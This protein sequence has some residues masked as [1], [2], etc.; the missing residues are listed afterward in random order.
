MPSKAKYPAPDLETVLQQQ[1]GII[2]KVA[3]M[4]THDEADF[5]DLVQDISVQVWLSLKKYKKSYALSTWVYRIALNV[6][7]DR[8]RREERRNKNKEAFRAEPL[9]QQT[10]ASSERSEQLHQWVQALPPLDRAL[11]ML[12]LEDYAHEEIAKMIG[13]SKSNV[14][15]K[16]SRLKNR[17]KKELGN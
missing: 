11:M 2:F 7:I 3:R 6:S 17:L 5:E 12:Y 15:T 13:I 16:I 10:N 8:L 1:R 4:Y 14:G 9:A